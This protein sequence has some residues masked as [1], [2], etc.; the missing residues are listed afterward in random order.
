MSLGP[1]LHAI[2]GFVLPGRPMADI[3]TDHARLPVD[4]V[5]RG[6]TP[7]AIACDVRSGPLE[8]AGRT[9]AAAGCTDRVALRLGD[10]LEPLRPGEAE[11]VVIAGM[12]GPSVVE[13]LG[14]APEPVLDGVR[15][16]VLA[17]HG[18]VG[19]V[20]GHLDRHGWTIVDEAMVEEAGRLYPIVVA[21]PA[22][23][24]E[25]ARLDEIDV[26]L[27]PILRQ[28]TRTDPA[29]RAWVA[30]ELTRTR[31]ALAGLARAREADVPKRR[32]LEALAALLARAV[33]PDPD[34]ED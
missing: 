30:Q 2:A 9:V 25:A 33:D 6:V 23:G 15:R 4:L 13:I 24:P 1:R 21:A 3:G 22:P 19:L 12:G 31:Q 16:L 10:G 11:T 34:R 5:T 26:A 17:P 29:M 14:A 32:E 18:G 28:R 7:R 8:A 20:R 27:G